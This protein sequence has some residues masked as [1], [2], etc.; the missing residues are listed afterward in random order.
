VAR[1]G[2]L[3]LH[4]LR[5]CAH[6]GGHPAGARGHNREAL[7]LERARQ[8][9]RFWRPGRRPACQQARPGAPLL[10]T[11]PGGALPSR[12]ASDT[13]LSST[14]CQSRLHDDGRIGAKQR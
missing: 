14:G 13:P 1:A 5:V 6:V 10:R 7:I 4:N 9:R 3:H 11:A 8:H 12:A 2:R